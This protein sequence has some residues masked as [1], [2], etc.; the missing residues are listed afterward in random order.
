MNVKSPLSDVDD[1][2]ILN[3]LCL[4]LELRG[5]TAIA[6]GLRTAYYRLEAD[7]RDSEE[8]GEVLRNE[9]PP[10]K[11]SDDAGSQSLFPNHWDSLG[12]YS[13][14]HSTVEENTTDDVRKRSDD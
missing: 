7:T 12:N 6:H 1:D 5:K 4:I 13:E 11:T 2:D 8:S 3:A 9:S 10:W 14:L